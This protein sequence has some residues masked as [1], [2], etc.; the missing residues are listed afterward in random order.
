M[1]TVRLLTQ[2]A[3]GNVVA[4]A[5]FDP[6]IGTGALGRAGTQS[7]TVTDTAVPAQSGP[8]NSIA[9][10]APAVSQFAMS[11][12]ARVT[13]G[14]GFEFTVWAEDAFGNVNAGYRGTVH[15]SSTDSTR[16]HAENHVQQQR[17]RRGHFQLH[18]QRPWLPDP[19]N[20]GHDQLFHH[21]KPAGGRCA[22]VMNPTIADSGQ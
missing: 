18:V 19:D 6:P 9:V 21:R 8:E 15:L 16:G 7:I 14:V 5:V 20:R 10:S 2:G 22:E 3:N 1:L 11:S 13:M 12:P 4:D 17:Q